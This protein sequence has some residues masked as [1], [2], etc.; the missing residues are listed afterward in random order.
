[1]AGV[2]LR[3][4][5]DLLGHSKVDMVFRYAHLSPQHL[6][7]SMELAGEEIGECKAR[8]KKSA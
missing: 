3:S 4:L 2:T 8:V 1:M 6:A 7:S 5:A